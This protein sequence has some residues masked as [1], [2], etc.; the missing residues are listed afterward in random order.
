VFLRKQKCIEGY[1]QKNIN[2]KDIAY[3][4]H[5]KFIMSL[6]VSPVPFDTFASL[7]LREHSGRTG[8]DRIHVN[9]KR[10]GFTLLEIIIAIAII[11]S[12]MTLI[13]NLGQRKPRYEREQFIA[14]L[15]S[16][17]QFAWQ[18]AF[19]THTLHAVEFDLTNHRVSVQK[20][21]GEKDSDGFPKT[22]PVKGPRSRFNFLLNSL[23]K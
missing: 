3:M 23:M 17:C 4:K 11:A 1:G 21:T 16:L 14:R 13:P 2:S 6:I 7:T 18:Q 20:D 5:I 15:N 12:L 19:M 9:A 10:S 22:E 8:L